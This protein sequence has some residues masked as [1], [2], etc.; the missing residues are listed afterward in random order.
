MITGFYNVSIIVYSSSTHR[1][2][3]VKLICPG[4]WEISA[5]DPTLKAQGMSVRYSVFNCERERPLVDND[6]YD[7]LEEHINEQFPIPRSFRKRNR[8]V[9]IQ[10]CQK[11]SSNTSQTEQQN[12]NTIPLETKEET[13]TLECKRKL[14]PVDDA[15]DLDILSQGGIPQD[16]LDQLNMEMGLSNRQKRPAFVENDTE[17]KSDHPPSHS[18]QT[19]TESMSP[20]GTKIDGVV[21][22]EDNKT[23]RY[24]DGDKPEKLNLDKSPSVDLFKKFIQKSG[25]NTTSDLGPKANLTERTRRE[26]WEKNVSEVTKT[27]DAMSDND[28]L[29]DSVLEVDKLVENLDPQKYAYKDVQHLNLSSQY[30][31][32][33]SSQNETDQSLP[34]LEYDDYEDDRNKTILS[35]SSIN[36]IDIRSGESMFR[37]YYIAAE[38]I[39][40]DYGIDKP[41]Q[42][43]TARW[44]INKSH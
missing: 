10:I 35:F 2:L 33:R 42:L 27:Y 1:F 20:K 31:S 41:S 40:W 6:D 29:K 21:N 24:Q 14:V 9:T 22:M 28:V 17:S 25:L 16:I 8:T 15:E 5:F 12:A 11:V 23:V 38:E 44:S 19:D 34:P 36:D 13:N 3:H 30:A 26:I 43:I 32:S 37:S 7:D 18:H 39:M 4:E